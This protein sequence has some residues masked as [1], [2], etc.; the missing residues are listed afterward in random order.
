MGKE[1]K[2]STR[3]RSVKP[4]AL[5]LFV[6]KLFVAGTTPRSTLA[7][8]NAKELCEKHLGGRYRLEVIDIYQ[9]PTLAEHM[10]IIALPTLIRSFPRPLR[11]FIGDMSNIQKLVGGLDLSQTV[12]KA[13]KSR[14]RRTS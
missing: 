6:L 2:V 13:V 12:P 11:R 4:K 3:R 5:P 1:P 7:I 9:Q 10:D 8:E 14:A